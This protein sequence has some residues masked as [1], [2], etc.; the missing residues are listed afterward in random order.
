MAFATDS[1]ARSA[2]SSPRFIPRAWLFFCQSRRTSPLSSA[3][4]SQ[5]V[6]LSSSPFLSL[7]AAPPATLPKSLRTFALLYVLTDLELLGLEVLYHFPLLLVVFLDL[8]E[9]ASKLLLFVY[10]PLDLLF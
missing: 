9:G 10:D 3:P 6:P 2:D 7:P 5:P 4:S 8:D 1:T